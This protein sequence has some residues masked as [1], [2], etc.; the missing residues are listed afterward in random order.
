VKAK[1]LKTTLYQIRQNLFYNY[2]KAELK[3]PT[4]AAYSGV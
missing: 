3:N 1:A 4:I 2:L